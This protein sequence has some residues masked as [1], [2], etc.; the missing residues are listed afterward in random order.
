[1]TNILGDYTRE[2]EALKAQ[3]STM[4]D[5]SQNNP[6]APHNNQ[7]KVSKT[8]NKAT[9]DDITAVKQGEL[10]FKI[11][12]HRDV[13]RALDCHPFLPLVI[14]GGMEKDSTLKLWKINKK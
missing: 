10:Y 7:K 3:N 1:M 12:S 6:N 13:I 11:K 8:E 5:D 2:R 14:A 9:I 4:S